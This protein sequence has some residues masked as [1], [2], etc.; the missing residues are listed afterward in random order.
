MLEK[1][2]LIQVLD[3]ALSRGAD[4]A[5]V[6][7]EEKRV[8]N[9]LC[10][11]NRVEKINSG[12]E[13]GAGIRVVRDGKTAYVHTNNLSLDGLL[14]AAEVASR[15]HKARIGSGKKDLSIN[16]R[17]PDFEMSF[18]RLPEQV[19][20][21]E[22]IRALLEANQ[23]VRDLD[24]EIR[25]VIVTLGDIHKKVQIANSEGEQ[26]EDELSRVRMAVNAVAARDGLI[27]TGYDAAGAVSGWELL[28]Q[29]SFTDMAQKA[30]ARAIAMLSAHPAPAGRMP[31]VM[32]AEAGG[33][34]VHEAC[35]HGL[36]ADLVHKGLSVYG[37]KE[38]QAVASACVSVVDDATLPGKYGSY[39]WDDEGIRAQKT[40]LIDKG[41]LK[42]FLYD[43]L[44]ALAD[45][46]NSSGNGR[47]ESY[48]EKP[49]P[50]MSNTY[51]APGNDDPEEIVQET[52]YGLLVKKMGG[53]QVNTT[54]GD[55][56]FDVQEGYVIKDGEVAYPVR[57]A[58]LSGNGPRVLLDID[59]VGRD[60][61]FG[62]GTCGKGGQGVPVGDAQPTLR[63][64]ELTVG[65]TSI[66]Q[67]PAI[68]RIRRR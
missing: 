57:G 67:G 38:G 62:I 61:G 33:T 32:H 52:N 15:S 56:V 23:A 22:K 43:R 7:V 1:D 66:G 58:T 29:V 47:R 9:V 63:I 25:Q 39:R 41:I 30:G 48:Q 18:K 19:D 6:Y 16:I 65:G 12:H 60:L 28:D 42:G 24:T 68:K 31:V 59:R 49:I 10:E 40:V 4:F 8:S 26:I 55:F 5:E 44:T 35:G 3:K 36:E 2:V 11:E 21:A 51:I 46:T 54:N 37:D 64:K 20:F 53:G 13:I 50:R 14:E 17:Q 27:Q 34:M 45:K